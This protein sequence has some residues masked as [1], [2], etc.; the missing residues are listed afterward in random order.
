MF[1]IK[2]S[3]K[4]LHLEKIKSLQLFSGLSTS[5]LKRL[6]DVAHIRNYAEGE[7]I[8]S[9]GTIG[10]CFYIIV[11]GS[12]NIIGEK[13]NNS[14]VLKKINE[15][16]SF[17]EIHLF[18]EITHSVSAVADQI[19]QLIV[20]TKPDIEN[21]IKKEPKLGSKTLLKFLEYFGDKLNELYI[22]NKN[23]KLNC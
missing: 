2:S 13:N 20:F 11:K 12:V 8:F 4:K 10:L 9:Q 17:S 22:E 23:L 19:T 3:D 14:M 7:I 5:E 15:G 18:T 6:L 16:D 1:G 21:L